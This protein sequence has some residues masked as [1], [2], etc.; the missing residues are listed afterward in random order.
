MSSLDLDDLVEE[1]RGRASS[2]RESQERLSSLLDAVLAVSSNLDLAEVLHRIVVVAC[3]L[4]DATYGALGVLG[5]G[6]EDLVEF[7]T[8]GL[9]D[10]EREAIGPL[11]RGHGLLGLIIESPKPQRVRNIGEH[12]DSY[13][14]PPHHPPMTSFLGAPVRIRDQVF[15]NLYLTDKRTGP[16]FSE[17]DEAILGALAAAAGVAIDNA[18]LYDGVR[19]QQLWGEVIGNATQ[20]LLAGRPQGEVLAE[21]VVGI[22]DLTGAS[23]CLIALS[24]ESELVVAATTNGPAP[25]GDLPAAREPVQDAE[26]RAALLEPPR[27]VARGTRA[28]RAH[29]PLALGRTPLGILVVDWAE[30]EQ[31][32]HLTHLAD[33]GRGLAVSLGAASAR[34]ERAR[35]ELFEDRERIAR[36]MHD[37]VIQRLFATGMSLQSA[38]PMSEPHVRRKLES[39][40]DE[41]DAAIKD[42]RHAIFALH[43]VPGARPLS[44]EIATVCGDAAVTLGFA[45]ELRLSGRMADIPDSVSADLLA[46]VREALSN[47]ARHASASSAHVSVEV[48]DD[49]R[50]VVADDGRGL[51]SDAVRSGLANLARRAQNRGGTFTLEAQ[52]P[53]GTSLVWCVPLERGGARDLVP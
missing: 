16:E 23:A 50:V 40:V 10:D 44:A 26:L 3:E 6:G 8:H 53:S 33:F 22:Q 1:L 18:R 34:S 48:G 25:D 11:P 35:S 17:D 51:P 32:G 27:L 31:S 39:A 49:V 14:F 9:T 13:G 37:N 12:P 4:V 2:A 29:V 43:R 52:V 38:A 20:S 21:V 47:V 42:I 24:D 36:D 15:G 30:G 7:V 28:T 19:I 45:P 41:L 46:V 5:P